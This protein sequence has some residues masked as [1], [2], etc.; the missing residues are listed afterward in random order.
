[1]RFFCYFCYYY[2]YYYCHCSRGSQAA[3]G[4]S[5]SWVSHQWVTLR[6]RED[7]AGEASM[8]SLAV[9]GRSSVEKP[10]CFLASSFPCAL[11]GA[12]LSMRRW[13]WAAHRAKA[14][15]LGGTVSREWLWDPFMSIPAI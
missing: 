8:E 2:Y 14:A 13:G 11:N 1:M 3:A 5:F 4:G 7:D 9:A 6:H 12:I 10:V 15:V